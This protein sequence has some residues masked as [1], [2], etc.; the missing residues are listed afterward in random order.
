MDG[1]VAYNSIQIRWYPFD[2]HSICF[3]RNFDNQHI[4]IVIF[5]YQDKKPRT[6]NPGHKPPDKNPL[7][8]NPPDKNPP[9]KTYEHKIYFT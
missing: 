8:E 9:D 3:H 6:K 4:N 7:D 2:I 5:G 1:I